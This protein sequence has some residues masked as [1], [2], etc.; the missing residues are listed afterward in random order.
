[1]KA[2]EQI[3]ESGKVAIEKIQAALL[4]FQKE[5]GLTADVIVRWTPVMYITSEH[6]EFVLRY[7]SLRIDY[8]TRGE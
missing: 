6:E 5:T 4:E 8:K 3:Q 7:V 1:M 2:H